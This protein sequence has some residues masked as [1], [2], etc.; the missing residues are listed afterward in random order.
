MVLEGVTS[1]SDNNVLGP[2]ADA[3]FE[4]ERGVQ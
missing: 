2:L 4:R 1:P 3:Q